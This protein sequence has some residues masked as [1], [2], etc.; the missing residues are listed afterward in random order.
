ASAANRAACG[1]ASTALTARP[2]ISPST[3]KYGPG[4]R[5]QCVSRCTTRARTPRPRV[6]LSARIAPL[7]AMVI[8]Q[9]R[10]VLGRR[11]C[12]RPGQRL[13]VR[14][15]TTCLHVLRDGGRAGWWCALVSL[16]AAGTGGGPRPRRQDSSTLYLVQCTAYNTRLRENV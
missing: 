11:M 14:S 6:S 8:S 13:V 9:P 7:A 15:V 2:T 5:R 1:G 16:F 4:P 12:L 10:R 3:P